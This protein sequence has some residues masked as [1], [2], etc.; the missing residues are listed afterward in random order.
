MVAKTTI[1]ANTCNIS[2]RFLSSPRSDIYILSFYFLTQ[3]IW[4]GNRY[5]Q[6]TTRYIALRTRHI[7]SITQ[8]ID[9]IIES[10]SRYIC[11]LSRTY[12]GLVLGVQ[13]Q[14][15]NISGIYPQRVSLR[16]QYYNHVNQ[17]SRPESV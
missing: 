13:S 15:P 6:F 14:I 9:I 11:N 8:Y 3:Y 10:R 16:V 4:F 1:K 5:I 17:N 7:D 12:L 2:A